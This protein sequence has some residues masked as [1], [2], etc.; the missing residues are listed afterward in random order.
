MV[1]NVVE[2]KS[3]RRN[4]KQI[5]SSSSCSSSDS[6]NNSGRFK[7]IVVSMGCVLSAKY[8]QRGGYTSGCACNILVI[9]TYIHQQR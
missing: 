2:V 7:N 4:Y 6:I 9:R 5:S 1:E 3:R 8:W